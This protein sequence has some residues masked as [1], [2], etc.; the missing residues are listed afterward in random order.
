MVD[1]GRLVLR[2]AQGLPGEADVPRY[3]DQRHSG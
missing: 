2:P 3:S 1:N